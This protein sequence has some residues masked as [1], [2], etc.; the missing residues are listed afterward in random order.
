MYALNEPS[1]LS[2]LLFIS[3]LYCVSGLFTVEKL[4]KQSAWS[5]ISLNLGDLPWT[6]PR[7]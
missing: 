6:D 2:M 5:K 1:N 7:R 4:N 3:D